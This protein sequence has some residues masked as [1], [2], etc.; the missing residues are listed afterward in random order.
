M[1][2]DLPSDSFNVEKEGGGEA[3]YSLAVD[4]VVGIPGIDWFL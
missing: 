2:G 4:G 3:D 1:E